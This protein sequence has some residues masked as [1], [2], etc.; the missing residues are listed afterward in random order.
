MGNEISDWKLKVKTPCPACN[1]KK[2]ID[3]GTG[4][5]MEICPVCDM[6][7]EILQH[8][9]PPQIDKFVG[10]PEKTEFQCSCCR[11]REDILRPLLHQIPY[12]WM[13]WSSSLVCTDCVRKVI[14]TVV[15]TIDQKIRQLK[16]TKNGEV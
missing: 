9:K 4:A 8:I 2:Y 14:V 6:K 11:K 1:G 13:N 12:G 10:R 3:D 16:E 7:G 15:A 5:P